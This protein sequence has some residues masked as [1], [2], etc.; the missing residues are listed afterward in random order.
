MHVSVHGSVWGKTLLETEKNRVQAAQ[1]RFVHR[2]KMSL[3]QVLL[4]PI[5]DFTVLG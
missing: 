5:C 3:C 1:L 2:G 4:W